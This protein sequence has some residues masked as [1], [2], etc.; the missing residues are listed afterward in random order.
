M[1][2]KWFTGQYWKPWPND[3]SDLLNYKQYLKIPAEA[4]THRSKCH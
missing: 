4:I 2:N 1:L 3:L